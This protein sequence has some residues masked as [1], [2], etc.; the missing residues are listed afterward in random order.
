M[1]FLARGHV[2][3]RGRFGEPVERAVRWVI[4]QARDGLI[5]RDTSH[6]PLYS[7]GIS[8]LMLGEVLGM[9]SEERPGFENLSRAYLDA[10]NTILR[11]QNVAKDSSSAGGWRYH[12]N[13]TDSDISVSAWQLLALRGAM[14]NELPVPRRNIEGAVEYIKRCVHP[15][16]GFGYQPGGDPTPARTGTGILALQICGDF[17]SPEASRGGDW[18]LRHPLEWKGPFFFYGAY[19]CSQGMYQL[20]GEH[21]RRW[22]PLMESLLLPRQRADGSWPSPPDETLEIH[23]GPAYCTAMAALALSVDFKLLPIYQR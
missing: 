21:W 5:L 11:A 1:A 3:G 13:S 10:V 2:P 23:A 6:G 14:E 17:N 8:T 7:H 4:E 22:R 12:P 9:V 19:Y 15:L 20:G 18:L 16:G